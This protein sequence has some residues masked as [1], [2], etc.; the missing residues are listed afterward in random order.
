MRRKRRRGVGEGEEG[1]QQGGEELDVN[2]DSCTFARS[3][4][5]VLAAAC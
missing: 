3:W 5:A 1:R 2:T 4:L